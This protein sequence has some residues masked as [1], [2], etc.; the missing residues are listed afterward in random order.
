ML[1]PYII[2]HFHY[3]NNHKLNSFLLVLPIDE[4]ALPGVQN[5]LS[6][7]RAP[8]PVTIDLYKFNNHLSLGLGFRV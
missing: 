2:I 5:Q 3:S 7:G 1:L 8:Q 4:P 6:G